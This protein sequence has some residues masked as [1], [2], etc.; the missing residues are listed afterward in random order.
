MA[1]SRNYFIVNIPGGEEVLVDWAN[2]LCKQSAEAIQKRTT[3][4]SPK[5]TTLSEYGDPS[6]F[7]DV[8]EGEVERTRGK[9]ARAPYGH[10]RAYY[11]KAGA[12][13]TSDGDIARL[14]KKAKDAGRV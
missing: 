5:F 2:E 4:F 10:R 8:S 11:V 7:V 3:R 1:K 14:L 12:F 9:K 13:G 6:G